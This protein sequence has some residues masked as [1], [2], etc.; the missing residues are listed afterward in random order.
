MKNRI[1]Y[2]LVIGAVC[3]YSAFAQT[4]CPTP[5]LGGSMAPV[6]GFP[7]FSGQI[8]FHL[9]TVPGLDEN[10]KNQIRKSFEKWSRF[11]GVNNQYHGYSFQECGSMDSSGRPTCGTPLTRI[12]IKV[13]KPPGANVPDYPAYTIPNFAQGVNG[14]TPYEPE[15][16]LNLGVLGFFNPFD[17]RIRQYYDKAITKAV[18]HE[19]GHLH[20]LDDQPIDLTKSCGGQTPGGSAMNGFCGVNDM[21]DNM[22]SHPTDIVGC[23]RDGVIQNAPQPPGDAI[24]PTCVRYD[25]SYSVIVGGCYIDYCVYETVCDGVTVELVQ[26]T[27]GVGP[28]VGSP[29]TDQ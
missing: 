10:A 14:I 5:Q 7:R 6:V 13:G 1:L 8:Y 16:Y 24:N 15:I 11:T 26:Y 3:S 9:E 20:G 17:Q 28:C 4:K 22:A 25:G 23:D 29:P 21:A 12:T 27:C 2:V 18:D 19:L